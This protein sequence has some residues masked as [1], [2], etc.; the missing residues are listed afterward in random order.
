MLIKR[1]IRGEEVSF[2]EDERPFCTTSALGCTMSKGTIFVK[3]IPFLID[4]RNKT[5]STEVFIWND[6]LGYYQK[7][8]YYNE[9]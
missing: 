9:I 1:I 3:D 7:A 6:K 5:I 4:F 8:D 2:F